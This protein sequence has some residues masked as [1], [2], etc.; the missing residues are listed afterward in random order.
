MANLIADKAAARAAESCQLPYGEVEGLH[1]SEKLVASVRSRIAATFLHAVENDVRAPQPPADD[2]GTGRRTLAGRIAASAHQIERR[3]GHLYC[4]HCHGK[5][6]AARSRAWLASACRVGE[7]SQDSV[8]C[9][10]VKV[11]HQTV[12]PSHFHSFHEGLS[13]HYCAV[14][15]AIARTSTRNPSSKAA[16]TSSHSSARTKLFKIT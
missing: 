16:Q 5:A 10:A 4:H 2:R 3:G 12:H 7:R 14:C 11:G 1:W 13:L 15:G 8:R 6:P 9:I